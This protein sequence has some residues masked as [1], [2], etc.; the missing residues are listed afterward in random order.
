[1]QTDAEAKQ[2]LAHLHGQYCEL[3]QKANRFV[4]RPVLS[5]HWACAERQ[6]YQIQQVDLTLDGASF[7]LANDQGSYFWTREVEFV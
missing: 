2:E 3:R 6:Q 5:K 1:M 7:A 4:G